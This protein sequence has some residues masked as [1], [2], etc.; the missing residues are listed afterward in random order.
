MSDTERMTPLHPF[1]WNGFLML[2][3][4][5]AL[6]TG[7]V[8][9]SLI[10]R[11]IENRIESDRKKRYHT[12]LNALRGTVPD[13]V[14]LDI[15]RDLWVPISHAAF[16][17]ELYGLIK[18]EATLRKVLTALIERKLIFS[19]KGPGRYDPVEYQL[20]HK[21]LAKELHRMKEQGKAGYQ[22]LTLSEVDTFMASPEYQAVTPLE[23]DCCLASSSGYQ[24]LTPGERQRPTP[25]PASRVS[26]RDTLRGAEVAPSNRSLPEEPFPEAT[27]E[28]R[29]ISSSLE[30]VSDSAASV[31]EPG[32]LASDE[33]AL[34]LV[35]HKGTQHETPL[36]SETANER[37]NAQAIPKDA[38]IAEPPGDPSACAQTECLARRVEVTCSPIPPADIS[39]GGGASVGMNGSPP[40]TPWTGECLLAAFETKR[41]TPYAPAIRACQLAATSRMAEYPLPAGLRLPPDAASFGDFYAFVNDRWTQEHYGEATPVYLMEPD[42][43]SGQPRF[44]RLLA[45]YFAI[46]ARTARS[47][48]TPLLTLEQQVGL[49]PR[50]GVSGR[51]IFIPSGEPLKVLPPPRKSRPVVGYTVKEV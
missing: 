5:Y 20:N 47:C 1:P 4:E 50:I 46:Q 45:R 27:A 25:S 39:A 51:P 49:R 38:L 15:E 16:L 36:E 2:R 28:K 12:Q 41:G 10:L 35:T 8:L 44:V 31:V 29:S 34:A 17:Y 42:K 22:P 40:H 6:L 30:P 7:D 26:E 37:P 43:A 32:S 13:D 14:I 19:R 9:Q 23:N 3:L 21:L 24:G 48:P 33:I 11:I 18:T